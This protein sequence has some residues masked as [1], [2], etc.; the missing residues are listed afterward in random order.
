MVF[1]ESKKLNFVNSL[2]KFNIA[3]NAE[4]AG[5]NVNKHEY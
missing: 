4:F 5:S 3:V 2:Y 1:V